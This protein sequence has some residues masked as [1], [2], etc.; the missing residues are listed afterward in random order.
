M[1]I[2]HKNQKVLK[3]TYEKIS[4]VRW[5]IDDFFGHVN[6]KTHCLYSK[7]FELDGLDAKFYLQVWLYGINSNRLS[8][9]LRVADMADKK[10]IFVKFKFWL[11]ND[12]GEKYAETPGRLL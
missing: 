6:K 8:Y 5:T 10:P 11:E 12:K 1:E 4:V 9:Y 2:S 3:T 7:K